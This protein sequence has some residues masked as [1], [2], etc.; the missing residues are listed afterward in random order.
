[1]AKE[2]SPYSKVK[3]LVENFKSNLNLESNFLNKRDEKT[4]YNWDSW[5]SK[6]H[7]RKAVE[8]EQLIFMYLPVRD[9]EKDIFSFGFYNTPEEVYV[10]VGFK[11]KGERE[12]LYKDFSLD[13]F[14]ETLRGFN[15]TV[16]GWQEEGISKDRIF[17][18]AVGEFNRKFINAENVGLSEKA[19][20][21]E[22]C[23]QIEKEEARLA[24]KH[25]AIMEEIS[26]DR[27]K[28]ESLKRKRNK[29]V[30]A[31][32][33]EVGF[34]EIE[35]EYLKIKERYEAASKRVKEKESEFNPEI[36]KLGSRINSQSNAVG[37]VSDKLKNLVSDKIKKYPANLRGYL[38]GEINKV[39]A[40]LSPEEVIARFKDNKNNNN[41][42][43]K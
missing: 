20:L 13:S 8:A 42:R 2:Q 39:R 21:K 32:K 33:E 43:I 25:T 15:K 22:V 11:H 3:A 41:N 10:S 6:E 5:D 24:S 34:E 1:M 19:I 40:K 35:A 7:T 27:K 12:V 14:R 26:S 16:K 29:E 37:E 9:F 17:I 30:K 4:V 38:E 18:K 36:Q 28:Q 23:E 31:V